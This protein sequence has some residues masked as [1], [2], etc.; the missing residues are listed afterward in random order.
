MGPQDQWKCFIATF[1]ETDTS[2]IFL[3]ACF[4]PFFVAPALT[5]MEVL[6]ERLLRYQTLLQMVDLV[7][8]SHGSWLEIDTTDGLYVRCK[9]CAGAHNDLQRRTRLTWA[10]WKLARTQMQLSQCRKHENYKIH[11]NNVTKYL[12]GSIG[13][14]A[15]LTAPPLS[16]FEKVVQHVKS[17]GHS[18]EEVDGVRDPKKVAKARFTLAEAIKQN[19]HTFLVSAQCI[20]IMRDERANNTLFRFHASQITTATDLGGMLGNEQG[21]DSTAEGISAATMRVYARFCTNF[22]NAPPACVLRPTFKQDVYN[23]MVKATRLLTVDAASKEQASGADMSVSNTVSGSDPL[24]PNMKHVLLD[25]TH[26]SRRVVEQPWKADLYLSTVMDMLVFAKGS[27]AHMIQWSPELRSWFSDMC[28]G[29]DDYIT[30]EFTNLRAAR[31]RMESSVEPLSRVCQKPRS[32]IRFLSRCAVIKQGLAPGR[33]ASHFLNILDDEILVSAAMLA[34]GLD[35]S[36]LLLRKYD[37][38]LP[39]A[40]LQASWNQQFL[41]SVTLL[42]YHFQVLT[43]PTHT[44]MMLK[45]LETKFVFEASPGKFRSLG[46]S[47][48]MSDLIQR[49]IKRMQL[50]VIL[51]RDCIY[52][53]MPE[54]E[55]VHSMKVFNIDE[56]PDDAA[57]MRQTHLDKIKPD[58]TRLVQTFEAETADVA[59]FQEELMYMVISA[60]DLAKRCT[61]SGIH[62]LWRKT[63]TSCLSSR[64]SHNIWR[65]TIKNFMLIFCVYQC[66][67]LSTSIVERCFAVFDR[68]FRNKRLEAG[69]AE[70]AMFIACLPECD[71][72]EICEAARALWQR[73]FPMGKKYSSHRKL[74]LDK[75]L[76]KH[77]SIANPRA[78]ST[79]RA[80]KRAATQAVATRHK[81]ISESIPMNAA[82]GDTF[83]TAGHDNRKT[84][85]LAKRY[86]KAVKATRVDSILPADWGNTVHAELQAAGQQDIQHEHQ[87]RVKRQ[88][89]HAV[90]E[91]RHLSS[92]LA[93]PDLTQLRGLTVV[94][95]DPDSP[96]MVLAAKS[97]SWTLTNDICQASLLLVKSPIAIPDHWN[98][99]VRLLGLQVAS[100]R[101]LTTPGHLVLGFSP[102][103]K[104]RRRIWISESFMTQ[105]AKISQVVQTC[106]VNRWTRLKSVAEFVHVKAVADRNKSS[107]TVIALVTEDECNAFASHCS[108]IYTASTFLDF[109]TIMDSART[110]QGVSQ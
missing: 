23:N 8:N 11:K 92:T 59:Q 85:T 88:K 74:R 98:V 14:D 82:V 9:A 84:K 97:L 17:G 13:H 7:G 58:C 93:F 56:W 83:W 40:A 71:E 15:N 63:V 12:T 91:A 41:D 51:S 94:L 102:A 66:I 54:F 69:N 25:R 42:F 38:E 27:I 68:L 78:S 49:C 104:T 95:A 90:N 21:F 101:S 20:N 32:S 16:F 65:C 33:H 109:I 43:L 60:K 22:T 87:N 99:A 37:S 67:Q 39:D 2:L 36:L 110:F 26:A 52:A 70:E 106:I 46:G 47:A 6:L 72:H 1:H 55:A 80:G 108:H 75:G 107:S 18:S 48:D 61:Y 45:V 79:F 34:D 62:D 35:E 5:L 3:L 31:H 28:A 96:D 44:K 10:K 24:L 29:E 100:Y 73:C 64:P 86:L 19:A 53:E 103:L 81:G 50:W 77:S 89:K 30:S 4:L 76:R 105:H 57:T